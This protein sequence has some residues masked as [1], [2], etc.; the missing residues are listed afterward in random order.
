MRIVVA[1]LVLVALLSVLGFTGPITNGSIG[2]VI[3]VAGDN[4][5]GA[6]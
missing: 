3:Q 2:P 4:A 5:P 1:G 6:N